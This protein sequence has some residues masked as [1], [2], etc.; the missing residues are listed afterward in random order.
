MFGNILVFVVIWRIIVLWF[1]IKIFFSSFVFVDLGVGLL[2]ELLFVMK[3]LFEGR[4]VCCVVGVLFD[5]VL[6]Y[7][8]IVFF[9]IMM[10]ISIDKCMVV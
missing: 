3:I 2:V 8:F 5:V 9:F 6:G 4:L 7:F 1:L 10:V